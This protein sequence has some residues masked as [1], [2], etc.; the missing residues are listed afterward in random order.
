MHHFLE[1][2]LAE[3]VMDVLLVVAFCLSMV[4]YFARIRRDKR[5]QRAQKSD[6]QPGGPRRTDNIDATIL[7]HDDSDRSISPDRVLS[8]VVRKPS[9]DE[10]IQT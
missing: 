7:R 6:G 2:V 3:Q 10:E 4:G 8:G 5:N 9:K 1:R